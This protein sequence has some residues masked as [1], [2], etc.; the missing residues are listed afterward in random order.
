M[1]TSARVLEKKPVSLFDPTTAV[2]PLIATEVPKPAPVAT[3]GASRRACCVQVEP[4][5][6]N[7]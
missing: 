6:T 1:L 5:R 7:T 3:N 2:S 4:D